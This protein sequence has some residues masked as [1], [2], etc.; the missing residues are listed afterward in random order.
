MTDK[1]ITR[2]Q[3]KNSSDLR[4][5][6]E[7]FNPFSHSTPIKNSIN[8]TNP[9]SLS[10]LSG[11]E[12]DSTVKF[13]NSGSS[14]D[15]EITKKF[16]NQTQKD[17][18]SSLSAT[19][20]MAIPVNQTVSL[21]DAIKMVPEFDGSNISLGQFLEGCN[22]AREMI[23]AGSEGNLVKLI[24][25]KIFGEARQAIIGQT[26]TKVEE[27]KDFYRTI[28][29]PTKSVQQLI[30]ELGRE[31]QRDGESV[32]SF[33]NRIKEIGRKI[34]ETK[35]LSVEGLNQ[36]F[37]ESTNRNIMECFLQGLLPV[38]GQRIKT[39]DNINNIVAEAIQIE[40]QLEAQAALRYNRT[41][42]TKPK[43]IRTC[44]LCKKEGHE[45]DVCTSQAKCEVCKKS[46]HLSKNCYFR[47]RESTQ[48]PQINCQ[49]C[50][51]SGHTAANCYLI[52]KCQLCQK[53][54]HVAKDCRDRSQAKPPSSS[55]NCQ[56]C[57]QRG[58]RATECR[59]QKPQTIKP[60]C[61]YC[62]IEG[63][64]IDQCRKR[65]YNNK[66]SGNGSR[67]FQMSANKEPSAQPRSLNI[68]QMDDLVSD[69]LPLN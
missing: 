63:H 6:L 42:T 51:K 60:K 54:G 16:N 36:A 67:P 28:Y 50:N 38:I 4:D 25:S 8:D 46:G 5:E 37:R 34:L 45:A 27:L 19:I 32:L 57:D 30:G 47:I 7:T 29:V 35:K 15:L 56:L 68:V 2:T 55:V 69:L 18:E 49:L 17:L 20:N 61:A 39:L 44:Q 64:S 40:K 9:N 59:N 66:N 43:L 1:R 53:I 48:K 31:Y 41:E 21:K 10:L 12:F 33:T 13:V 23:E 58:H 24:R 22:E 11:S 52:T 62:K 65:Q 26:F 3:A 14:S